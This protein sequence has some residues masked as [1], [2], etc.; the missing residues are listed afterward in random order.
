MPSDHAH[1]S[2]SDRSWVRRA[3]SMKNSGC[4]NCVRLF[5]RA[6][7]NYLQRQSWGLLCEQSASRV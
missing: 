1:G 5:L 3:W 2:G 4:F 7:L 6:V